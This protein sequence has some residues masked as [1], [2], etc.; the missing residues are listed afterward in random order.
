MSVIDGPNLSSSENLIF[1]LDAANFKSY[2]SSGA[3]WYDL[4]GNNNHFTLFSSPAYTVNGSTGTYFTFN[5]TNQY[6]RSTEAI[7]F[8]QYSAVTIEIAYRTQNTQTQILYETT[9]TGGSTAT[10]GI[11]LLMNS[12]NTSTRSDNYLTNWQGFGPRLFGFT[13]SS[14]STFVTVHETFVKTTD[15][16]GRRVHINGIP[17][18][19][20]TNTSVTSL[21]SATSSQTFSNTWTYIASRAG[22]SNFFNGDIAWIRAW[23]SKLTNDVVSFNLVPAI[24]RQNLS[25]N[26]QNI[27]IGISG[28][29]GTLTANGTTATTVGVPFTVGHVQSVQYFDVVGTVAVKLEAY[30]GAGGPGRWGGANDAGAPGGYAAG[31]YT[32]TAGRYYVFV[33]QGAKGNAGCGGAGGGSVDV[34]VNYPGGLA[35]SITD[36]LNNTSLNSRIIVAGGGGGAHG[37]GY[38]VFPSA[39]EQPGRGGPDRS[40]TNTISTGYDSGHVN[41]GAD[42]TQAGLDGGASQ[43]PTTNTASGAFGRGG[44]PT[45]YLNEGYNPTGSSRTGWGWPNGGAGTSYANGG[46]GGGWYGG[47]SNWPNAGGGS[48]YL[49]SSGI[50]TLTGTI[51]NTTS[52]NA[53]NGY[54]IITL[55]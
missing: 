52:A 39:T 29:G 55:L 36:F 45:S 43:D 3:T 46:G 32:L 6:A 10:G 13:R 50:A 48:N 20:S 26:P 38:G 17:G 14:T 22:I 44:W 9:G 41:T 40:V 42:S 15:S 2:P 27:S 28:G 19:F 37:G 25:Y 51:S 30:G 18:V 4:S 11:T 34:R 23:S 8:N 47:A 54:L 21:S 24:A 33:G 31:N 1:Y 7:N 5:G 53:G 12:D 35:Y 16:T 49:Q